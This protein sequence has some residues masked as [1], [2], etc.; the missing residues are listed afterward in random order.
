V[1]CVTFFGVVSFGCRG[2]CCVEARGSIV[3]LCV[4]SWCILLVIVLG[5]CC[6]LVFVFMMRAVWKFF[7]F[8]VCF[9]V[10]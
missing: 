1:D 2:G 5:V 3:V 6:V 7:G 9:G 10:C 4:S 8:C